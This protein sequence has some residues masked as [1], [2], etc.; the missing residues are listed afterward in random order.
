MANHTFIPKISREE[1]D[2]VRG[3]ISSLS[4]SFTNYCYT[5][6]A[7]GTDLNDITE[8]GFY[9]TSS[10]AV[11]ASLQNCPVSGSGM[12]M[13]VTQRGGNRIQTIFHGSKIYC[14]ASTSSGW[15][16]WYEFSGTAVS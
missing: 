16:Q 15:G 7:N 12:S 8:I 11:T 10:S 2:D 3:Q 9:G 1:I 13:M 14:R 4:D 6:L 5:A